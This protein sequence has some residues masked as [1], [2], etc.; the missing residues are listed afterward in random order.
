MAE[1]KN[2]EHKVERFLQGCGIYPAGF[3]EDK[4]TTTPVGWYFKVWGG[5][6]QKSGI[7]D[8]ICNIKGHFVAVELKAETGRPSALQ[9]LNTNRIRDS[10]GDACFLYP[11]GFED[12]KRDIKNLLGEGGE[13]EVIYT[14]TAE[15]YRKH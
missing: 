7:P 5:G 3:P 14:W 12:F 9:K 1:E 10:G 13:D 2:F 11:S 8:L 15:E 6:F 4:I